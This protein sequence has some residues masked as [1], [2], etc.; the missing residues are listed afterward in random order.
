MFEYEPALWFQQAVIQYQPGKLRYPLV[1]VRRVGKYQIV[2]ARG[3]S[4]KT[5]GICQVGIDLWNVEL[6]DV[7]FYETERF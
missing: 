1:P 7:L 2:S 6:P 3:V 5:K 4:D